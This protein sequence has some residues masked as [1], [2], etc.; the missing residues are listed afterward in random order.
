MVDLGSPKKKSGFTNIVTLI[1]TVVISVALMTLWAREDDGGVLHSLKGVV[2]TIATPFNALGSVVSIPFN[3]MSGASANANATSSDYLTLQQENSQ[4]KSQNS[5]IEQYRQ[6]NQRLSD[7]LNLKSSYDIESVAAHIVTRSSDSWNKT[8]TI[9][10]GS[11]DG[12]VVGMPVMDASGLLGQIES[13]SLTSS[14]VKLITDESSGVSVYLQDAQTEGILTGSVN[15]TLYIDYVPVTTSVQVGDTVITSGMGGVYP[16]GI[17]VGTVARVD[18][19]PTDTYQKIIVNPNTIS[20]ITQEVLVVTGNQ[21]EVSQQNTTA[22][23]ESSENNSSNTTSNSSA[24]T[25][26]SSTSSSST[27][28]SGEGQ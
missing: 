26:T 5:Q 15:G 12:M 17:Y 27:S 8:V 16:K 11:G 10:K 3:A 24:A 28:N 13:V 14:V 20:Y 9:D 19:N 1:V 23:T 2:A 18:S 22:Q 25:T 4:L 21:T 6:E 7:L